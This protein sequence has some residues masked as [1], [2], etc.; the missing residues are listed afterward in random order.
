MKAYTIKYKMTAA[1][2]ERFVCVL[3]DNKAEAW[4]TCKDASRA[5]EKAFP[6]SLWVQGVQY[7]NGKYKKF[8]TNEKKPY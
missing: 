1:E 4:L 3:A 2:N 7:Q 5:K 8:N 6:R